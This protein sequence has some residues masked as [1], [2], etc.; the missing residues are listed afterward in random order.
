MVLERTHQTGISQ[1]LSSLIL[2]SAAIARLKTT[3]YNMYSVY[4]YYFFSYSFITACPILDMSVHFL[5]HCI[6]HISA[7][8]QSHTY[9]L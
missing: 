8:A 3:F 4:L 7:K 9:F 1:L 5:L 2:M 6:I